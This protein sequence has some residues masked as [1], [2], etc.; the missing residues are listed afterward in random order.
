MPAYGISGP[1]RAAGSCL[2]FQ[3]AQELP[4]GLLAAPAGLG[5]DPAVLVHPGVLLALIAA[6]PADGRAGLQQR[7]G[8][9]GVVVC[10]AA[11]DLRGGGAETPVIERV[12]S[13]AT[14]AT[15]GSII[16]AI[17]TTHSPRKGSSAKPM[18]PGP[19]PIVR[20]STRVTAHA[21]AASTATAVHGTANCRG[22]RAC[23]GR[24]PET[25]PAWS[26]MRSPRVSLRS[27]NR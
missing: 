11:G 2:L 6:A 3:G 13:T 26:A 20:A 23:T 16:A 27:G 4:A 25:G 14:G 7:P 1:G 22:G 15:E 10:L 24:M 17:I 9:I 5:A 18:V 8:D 21:A 12:H 19:L